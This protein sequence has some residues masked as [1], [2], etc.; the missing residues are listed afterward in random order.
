MTNAITDFIST[1]GYLALFLLAVGE[2][3]FPPIPSEIV[4]TFT[5]F[6]TLSNETNMGVLGS[7]IISVIGGVLGSIILYGIG[8]LFSEERLIKASKGK[9]GKI[10]RIKPQ[11][12]QKTLDT[13]KKY[14]NKS[15]FIGRFIPV[16]RSLV[17]L[18]SGMTHQNFLVFTSLTMF[19]TIIWNTALIFAGRLAGNAYQSVAE[20]TD[21]WSKVIFVILLLAVI[22][23]AIWHFQNKKN[24][25]NKE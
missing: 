24:K 15:V 17:S 1:Y 19:G 18:P 20:S 21:R 5:G 13:Y 12:I 25:A 22:I 7:I 2:N 6:L 23:F 8:T 10:T 4:L 14:G 9:L 3:V 16:V 11:H